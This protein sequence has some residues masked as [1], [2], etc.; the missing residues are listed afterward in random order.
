MRRMEYYVRN[1]DSTYQ[2]VYDC[3]MKRVVCCHCLQIQRMY[4]EEC[5][6]TAYILKRRKL[7]I[8]ARPNAPALTYAH[9]PGSIPNQ[10]RDE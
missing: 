9:D 6:P 8:I 4:S 3:L 2:I 1:D 7:T 5:I 10:L